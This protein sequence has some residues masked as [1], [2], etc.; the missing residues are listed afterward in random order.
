MSN[1]ILTRSDGV[2]ADVDARQRIIDVIAVPW[3]QEA[4]VFWRGEF[5][6]EMFTRGAF[7]STSNLAGKIR[8]NREHR[9]GDTVGK[10]IEF[11]PNHERG[12]FARVKVV[13]GPK[14]D[15]LLHLAQEDMVSASIGYITRKPSDVLLDKSTKTR[16]VKEAFLDHIAMVEDP[17]YVGAEVLGVRERDLLNGATGAPLPATPL[18]D[19]VLRDPIIA[20]VMEQ[21]KVA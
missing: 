3:N 8:V 9:K 4:R 7:N 11:D 5:W 16:R 13:H 21:K 14:G 1:E 6:T 19:E 12:L 18:L 20:W 10:V 17:A 15:E 2:F